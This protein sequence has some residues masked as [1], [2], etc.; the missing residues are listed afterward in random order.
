MRL[1][2]PRWW[3]GSRPSDRL[4]AALLAPA[5]WAYG[6]AADARFALA[7]PYRSTLPVICVGNFTAG[8]AGKTPLALEIARIARALGGEPAFLT[9]GFGG[10]VEGPHWV[11]SDADTAADVGDEALLLAR[12]APTVVARNRLQ[13]AR[14][15]EA[16]SAGAIVMDDGFQNPSLVKDLALV[17]VDAGAGI[18]NGRVLPAGPLR[19]PLASQMQRAG[20]VVWIGDDETAF[21]GLPKDVPILRAR[22]VPAEDAA[23]IRSGPI[24]AYCGIGRPAKFFATLG[25]LGAQI[26]GT[27][28]F[29]DHH[30]FTE[31][32]ARDL[33]AKAARLGVTLVT[34]EKDWVRIDAA[35]P[36]LA[37]LKTESRMLPIKLA[38]APESEPAL[39]RLVAAALTPRHRIVT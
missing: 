19:A 6:A 11:K 1:E 3:Y 20:A 14:A 29:P 2:P 5:A 28:P 26:A 7:T 27:V 23:W 4:T 39:S 17:A 21:S 30:A 24:L 38:V 9:R 18:G 33:T 22:I 36:A 12:A 15:I 35:Q 16:S 32:D 13:G 25:E 37:K 34:T 31:D 10:T 8:G